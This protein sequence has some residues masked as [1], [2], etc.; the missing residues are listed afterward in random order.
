MSITFV[1]VTHNHIDHSRLHR[2]TL[3]CFFGVAELVESDDVDEEDEEDT[4]EERG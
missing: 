2:L 4:E 3:V 1:S